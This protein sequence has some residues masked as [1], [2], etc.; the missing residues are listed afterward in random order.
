MKTYCIKCDK[1][2]KQQSIVENKKELNTVFYCDKCKYEV[3]IIQ[4]KIQ[5]IQEK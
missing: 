5:M 2:M 3:L 4:K 1:E